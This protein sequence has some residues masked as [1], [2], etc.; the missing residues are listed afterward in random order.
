MSAT[1]DEVKLQELADEIGIRVEKF[2]QALTEETV[3]NCT[4]TTF[5]E[6]KEIYENTLEYSEA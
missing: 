2:R 1:I 5:V 3:Q 6:A 4:A